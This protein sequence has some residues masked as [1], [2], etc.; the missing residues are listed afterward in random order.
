VPL[1]TELEESSGVAV[2]RAHPGTYWTHA[3]GD[4]PYLYALDSAGT[5]VGRVRIE[6][7]S[8]RDWEDLE[9][10]E[11]DGGACL[12]LGDV[13][14]NENRREE[15]RVHRLREPD[16]RAD[17]VAVPETLTLRF[18]EGAR[19]AEALFVLPGERVHLVSK[20]R[21]HPIAVFRAPGAF[22]AGAT[23]TL[24]EVQRLSDGPRAIPRQVTGA[25]ATWDGS[26]VAIR[27]YET[28][29]LFRREG[30][31]LALVSR[32]TV[33]LR[34]LREAQGEAVGL[35]EDGVLVLTSEAGPM[36]GSGSMV[37]IRCSPPR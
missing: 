9:L 18:P 34:S 8:L 13:G 29:G 33:N 14:D 10:A 19:D 25:S 30:D 22:E 4:Q 31:T 6:G 11:C 7:V 37:A 16:P 5:L 28:V 36:G 32:G 21:E 2:S 20:G 1:P 3:D 27:T 23:V 26:L 12:Y 24:E 35:G 15:V 17:T